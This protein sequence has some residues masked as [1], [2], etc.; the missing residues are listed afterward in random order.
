MNFKSLLSK[1]LIWRIRH[2]RTKNFII[3]LGGVIGLLGGL[4]AVTLKSAVHFIQ[5]SLL[6]LDYS[7]IYI[8]F[9][10]VGILITALLANYILK[11][12]LGHGITAILYSISKNQASSAV[13][14]CT[15]ACL[16][17]VSP[18]GLE[19]LLG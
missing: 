5:N 3:I 2:I 8:F 15:V 11:E 7:Y 6:G 10:V 4:A 9:P 12:R 13:Q 19:V 1:F 18:L 17:L 16:H 14:K